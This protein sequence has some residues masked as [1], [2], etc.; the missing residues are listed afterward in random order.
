MRERSVK[1]LP[2]CSVNEEMRFPLTIPN[3]GNHHSL[4][5][6]TYH[7]HTGW[8][9]WGERKPWIETSVGAVQPECMIPQS[10]TDLTILLRSG[11]MWYE[12][13]YEYRANI[14]PETTKLYFNNLYPRLIFKPFNNSSYKRAHQVG[15]GSR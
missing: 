9:Q 11:S 5:P 4:F 15:H 3:T 14:G 8:I 2:H 12:Y 7:S 10:N 1:R 13:R 6:P